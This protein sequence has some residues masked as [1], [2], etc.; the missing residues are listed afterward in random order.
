MLGRYKFNYSINSKKINERL[1]LPVTVVPLQ[2]S[3]GNCS[4]STEHHTRLHV[5][6]YSV[7]QK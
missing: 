2:F 4:V 1:T 3:T 7:A 5:L 6:H